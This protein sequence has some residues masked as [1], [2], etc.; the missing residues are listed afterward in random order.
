M[1]SGSRFAISGTEELGGGLKGIFNIEHRLSPDTGTVTSG[2]TFWAG[3][4]WVG[5]QGGFGARAAGS[6]VH[7]D[8]PCAWRLAT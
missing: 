3:Q 4:A 1:W 2:A 5:L 8:V 7:P 6:S